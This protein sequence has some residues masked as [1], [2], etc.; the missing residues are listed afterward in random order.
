[1]FSD[2]CYGIAGTGRIKS[3][4]ARKIRA[5]SILVYFNQSNQDCAH[6]ASNSDQ[7][8]C[9]LS[10]SF[11]LGK[12]FSPCRLTNTKSKPDKRPLLCRKKS[13]ITLFTRFRPTAVLILFFETASPKRLNDNSFSLTNIR[14]APSLALYVGLPNTQL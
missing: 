5:D 9:N 8:L 14:N 13:L 3:A 6:F 1:M 2:G 12:L 7:R 10:T 11:L 4:V